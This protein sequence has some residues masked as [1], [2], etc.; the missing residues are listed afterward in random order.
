MAGQRDQDSLLTR[1]AP[2]PCPPHLLRLT[3]LPELPTCLNCGGSRPPHP[4][5]CGPAVAQALPGSSYEWPPAAPAQ[6]EGAAFWA[7]AGCYTR[8]VAVPLSSLRPHCSLPFCSHCLSSSLCSLRVS[9]AHPW[10]SSFSVTH[11][12][13]SCHSCCPNSTPPQIVTCRGPYGS[14]SSR[15]G[16]SPAP[17]PHPRPL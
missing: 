14:T 10:P 8:P 6:R 7:Y 9:T 16:F 5:G 12:H 4:G 3:S 13:C 11:P 1:P 17:R 2:A 15:L